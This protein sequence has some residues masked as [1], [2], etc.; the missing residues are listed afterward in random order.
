MNDAAWFSMA[1]LGTVAIYC[2]AQAV[3][4]L[5]AKRYVWAVAGLVSALVL[6]SIPIPSHAVKIDLPVTR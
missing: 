6:V 3:R 1:A 5:R 2:I 4:D